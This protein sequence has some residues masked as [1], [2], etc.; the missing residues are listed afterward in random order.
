[1][2]ERQ[3]K[4][5]GN[6]FQCAIIPPPGDFSPWCHT[7]DSIP[8]HVRDKDQNS[9]DTANDQSNGQARISSQ[10]RLEQ[11]EQL[12]KKVNAGSKQCCVDATQERIQ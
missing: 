10:A 9:Q 4:C 11:H 2:H 7:I 8:D 5:R 12:R 6:E 1:M 3:K